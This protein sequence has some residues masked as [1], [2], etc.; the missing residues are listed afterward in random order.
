MANRINYRKRMEQI[1]EDIDP[2]KGVPKL[3]LHS[4]C[5]PCSSA[6]IEELTRHF[7]ITVFYYNPN[8]YPP[9]E[10]W[11]RSKEQERFIREF[12]AH[13]PVSFVQ[14]AYENDRFYEM[15][16]GLE[17]EPERGARCIKC[18]RLRLEETA[19][20]AAANGYSFFT[21]TLSISPQKDSE[22]LNVIGGELAEKYSVLYLYSDFKK[23]D[24][25][26][27]STRLAAQYGMYRQDYCGCEY[28]YR[29][30]HPAEQSF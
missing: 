23:R 28:S 20:Y 7:E 1:I 25:Y 18:Y 2:D 15:A 12:P 6:V 13:Y 14:G 17:D 21:T 24:G 16:K 11:L 9:E 22:I 5:G 3:L 4:C 26:L 29:M 8:I 19:A 10:F 30:R 27:R